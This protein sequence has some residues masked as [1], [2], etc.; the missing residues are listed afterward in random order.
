M[1]QNRTILCLKYL[2]TLGKEWYD[3]EAWEDLLAQGRKTTDKYI[4]QLIKLINSKNFDLVH[5]E[6]GIRLEK[7]SYFKYVTVKK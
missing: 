6:Y 3:F 5:Q 1:L 4:K 2:D 7:K